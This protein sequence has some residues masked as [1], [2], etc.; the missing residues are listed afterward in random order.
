M[1]VYN[2]TVRD[3][4]ATSSEVAT[5][6]IHEVNSSENKASSKYRISYSNGK[7]SV[8]DMVSIDI[9]AT[10]LESGRKC[11]NDILQT[12]QC[13]RSTAVTAMNER[14][15]RSHCLFYLDVSGYHADADT[16]MEGGLRLVDLAGSERLARAGT[17]GDSSRFR[18][19]VSI[20]K[21]LSSLGEV[22]LALGKKSSHIPYRNSKLTMLLQV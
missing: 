14:S 8:S 9:N 4:L 16:Y 2:E 13:N 21:S 6:S 11:L 5:G 10:T 20:N 22:F 19:T 3:I 18:E 1:Q 15:S 17:G 12:A 7:V